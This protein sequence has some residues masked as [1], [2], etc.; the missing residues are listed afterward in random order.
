MGRDL[1]QRGPDPSDARGVLVS[2]T[3]SGREAQRVVGRRHAR[4]VAA[5]MTRH[6]DAEGLE[7]LEELC[8][9]LADRGPDPEDG[10]S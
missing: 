10:R 9:Q 4:H 6:L 3:D 7:R 5:A 8:S 1:I 2:L